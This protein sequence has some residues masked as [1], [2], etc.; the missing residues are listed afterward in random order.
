M[1]TAE[2]L[3]RIAENEPKV[4]EAGRKEGMSF[5]A[6]NVG[7]A[8]KGS[9]S[10][11]VVALK[12]VSPLVHN[13][14]VRVE[15][16]NLIP[17]PYSEPLNSMSGVN[18]VYNADGT[19]TITGTVTEYAMIHLIG[20]SWPHTPDA[21][22]AYLE[23]GETYTLSMTGVNG[24][25]LLP[26]CMIIGKNRDSGEGLYIDANKPFTVDKSTYSYDVL[27]VYINSPLFGKEFNCTIAIQLEKG[28]ATPYTPHIADTSGVKLLVYGGD[29]K[30]PIEYSQGE[31]I[32][33][34][35]PCTTLMT[36]TEGALITVEYNRDINK[37]FAEL[38][39]AIAQL[40]G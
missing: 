35:A 11:E 34:I 3:V 4:Y 6:D 9:A 8:L 30:D 18:F 39:K 29:Y 26:V 28:K 14:G 32:K 24:E 12:D 1:T 2:K 22:G 5:V 38:Q 15:S 13:L 36:D 17:Y 27:R 25:E 7:N 37:A 21:V 16:K 19:I 20:L 40:G 31:D 10:G 23:D 33:S